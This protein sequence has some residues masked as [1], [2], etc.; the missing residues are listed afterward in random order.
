MKKKFNNI[1]LGEKDVASKYFLFYQLWLELTDEKTLDTYQF[2]VMN[3]ISALEE[4]KKVL[5][6]RLNRYHTNNKN[7][8]ECANETALLVKKDYVL[9]EQYP[10]IRTRL[11]SHLGLTCDS[12]AA[13]RTLIH[14][15]D[16]CLK[17]IKGD[18]FQKLILSVEESIENNVVA[19]II[20]KTNQLVSCCV[21]RGWSAKA[22]GKLISI[23]N[24]TNQHPEN[25]EHFKNRLLNE[26]LDEYR[27]FLPLRIRPIS[28]AGQN[29]VNALEKVKE[30][31]RDM[32]ISLISGENIISEYPDFGEKVEHNQTYV[33]LRETSYDIY[34]ASHR[35]ISTFANV[36]NTLSFYNLVEAWNIRDISWIAVN[37]LSGYSSLLKSKD[38]YSTYDYLEGANKIFRSSEE[39]DKNTDGTLRTK[40]RATYSYANIG[41]VSYA[42]EDKYI[43]LWVA[44]ESLCRT[45]MYENI[46]SNVLET[47]PSALCTK[48]IYRCFR[49]FAE[50][51]LRCG[52]NFDLS[53][54]NIQ[55]KHPDKAK[56]VKDV[57]SAL[58]D[59]QLYQEILDKCTVNNLLIE[60]CKEMHN[61]ATDAEA[62]F[63]RIDSHYLN[64]RRQL[65]RLYRIRNEIAHSA[66]NDNTPL[67]QYIEHLEDYLTTFVSEIVQCW[68][69]HH[70]SDVEE[71]FE[72]IKDNYREYSDIKSAKRQANPK[73][74]LDNLRTTGIISLI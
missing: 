72:M 62:M 11:I 22:L 53:T 38:L 57:I 42:Q 18:Y 24:D 10:I 12:D 73:T 21:N 55:L 23:L 5:Y 19:D 35:A 39:L 28:A 20:G 31:I 58:N 40:L 49:N 64:V 71:I 33:D 6:Q 74:L 9:K 1:D 15:I 14:Q 56:V 26:N 8:E 45:D 13:Q 46:I 61:L 54:K 59:N 29:K 3:T 37:V 16:Y 30:K 70:D 69:N 34:T 7:I 47:V 60:R 52:V 66:L 67:L 50:D 48:Y 17:I 68:E 44:L 63:S 65:S 2:K 36:L 4:L 25:W 51:C 43:N 32:G 27:I 41:K